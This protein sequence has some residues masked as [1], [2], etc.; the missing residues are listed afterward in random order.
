M[1]AL[2]E[3]EAA[4]YANTFALDEEPFTSMESSLR[5]SLEL[6]VYNA[7]VQWLT[8]KSPAMYVS[9]H[10]RSILTRSG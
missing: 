6:N 8:S 2:R 9:F 10:C 5:V 1:L 3:L 4:T 7:F